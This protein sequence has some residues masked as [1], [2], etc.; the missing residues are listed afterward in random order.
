MNIG[1]SGQLGAMI[2]LALGLVRVIEALVQWASK[3]MGSGAVAMMVELGPVSMGKI[4]QIRNDG[5]L[6]HDMVT[7]T[8]L[9]GTPLVYGPRKEVRQ[10][11]KALG[12]DRSNGHGHDD[13]ES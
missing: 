12:A 11:L 6:I 3:K 13:D 10:V 9:D 4:E 2:A 5:E 8:D 1:D 7:R